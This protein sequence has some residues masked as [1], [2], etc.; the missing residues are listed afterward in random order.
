M[1]GDTPKDR[2]EAWA[3]VGLHALESGRPGWARR[4]FEYSKM[5]DPPAKWPEGEGPNEEHPEEP[6]RFAAF[7]GR[8]MIRYLSLR[9][10]LRRTR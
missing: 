9:E 5:D 8:W 10:R 1:I 2:R 4:A 6:K 3:L 7:L